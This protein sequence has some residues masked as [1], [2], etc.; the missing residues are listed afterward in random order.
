MRPLYLVGEV[1]KGF[2]RGSKELGFPTANLPLATLRGRDVPTG[3]Y[4]GWALVPAID[5]PSRARPTVMSVGF[6]P[7]YGNTEKTVEVHVIH[8]YAQ[9]FYGREVRAVALGY[10]RG[11]SDFE[12]L[13]ML[14]G[15]IEGDIAQARERLGEE[16]NAAY[17]SAAFFTRAAPPPEDGEGKE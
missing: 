16:E 9:D 10:L 13:E 15:A 4:F 2:G 6:N 7:Y 3:I 12:G 14:I 1:I 17:A 8:E 11:E 5:G